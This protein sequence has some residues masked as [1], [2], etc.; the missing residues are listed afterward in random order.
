MFA[1]ALMIESNPS[2]ALV[3]IAAGFEAFFLETMRINWKEK[4]LRMS[5]FGRIRKQAISGLIDWL[6][7]AVGLRSLSDGPDNLEAQWKSLVNERRND[8]VHRANVHFTS[9]Q[10]RESFGCAIRCISFIDE[11]GIFRPHVYFAGT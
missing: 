9:A 10:A 6:P 11:L 7:G 4:G 2:A 8:V 5:S 1:A 3:L